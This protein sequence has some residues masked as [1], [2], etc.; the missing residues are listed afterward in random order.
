[1]THV[2]NYQYVKK[3]RENNPTLYNKRAC[4]YSKRNYTWK[5][6]I[7]ELYRIDTTLFR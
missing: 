5:V 6:I 7:T 1:M 2:N 3:W 4:V